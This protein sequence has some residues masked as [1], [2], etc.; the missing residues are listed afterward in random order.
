M[1]L[2]SESQR[3]L[4]SLA[5]FFS[6]FRAFVLLLVASV[7]DKLLFACGVVCVTTWSSQFLGVCCLFSSKTGASVAVCGF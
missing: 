4:H 7:V 6:F 2:F 1:L 3:V 5:G